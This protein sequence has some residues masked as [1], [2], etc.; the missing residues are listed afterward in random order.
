MSFLN[1]RTAYFVVLLVLLAAMGCEGGDRE[2]E[3]PGKADAVG[4]E[5]EEV[6]PARSRWEQYCDSLKEARSLQ[7]FRSH[8]P[9]RN[10]RRRLAEGDH[11]FTEEKIR[12][13][14]EVLEM[15][16]GEVANSAGDE[17]RLQGSFER[18]VRA[19]NRMNRERG[20]F[21]ETL[22]REE[23]CEFFNRVADHVELKY[24]GGDITWEW[25]TDW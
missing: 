9:T 15:F 4:E 10:W 13:G 11:E 8:L 5:T 22:E 24:S 17:G 25:R 20:G 18:A 14:E 19:F 1:S 2:G 16:L 23:L 7:D 12:A 6:P 3:L 21:I